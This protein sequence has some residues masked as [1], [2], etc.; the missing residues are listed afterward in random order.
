VADLA[1]DFVVDF[2]AAEYMTAVG[3]RGA[4]SGVEPVV[5]LLL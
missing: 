1:L 5:T 4:I 2:A 3:A